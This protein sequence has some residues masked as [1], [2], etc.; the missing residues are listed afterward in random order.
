MNKPTKF[1]TGMLA[2]ALVFGMTV[3]GQWAEKITIYRRVIQ[4]Q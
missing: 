1:I 3:I 2:M 4:W